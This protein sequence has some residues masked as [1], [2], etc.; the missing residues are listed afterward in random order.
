M[1]IAFSAML[2]YSGTFN[3]CTQMSVYDVIFRSG[4]PHVYFGA[5]WGSPC[6]P[7]EECSS[8]QIAISQ[9]GR[10]LLPHI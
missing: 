5:P 2:L 3:R 6:T 10:E 8:R 4:A 1:E 7:V 9:I